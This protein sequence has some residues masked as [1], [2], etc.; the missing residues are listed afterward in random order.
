MKNLKKL[1][2]KQLRT[3]AGG[4]VCPG[5]ATWCFEWCTW[6]PWQKANCR[7]AVIDTPCSC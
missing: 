3:I 4:E 2:K 1:T 6:T 7:N 5:I